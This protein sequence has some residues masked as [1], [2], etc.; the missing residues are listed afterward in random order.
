[1][2]SSDNGFSDMLDPTGVDNREAPFS[3]ETASVFIAVCSS[4]AQ[5]PLIGTTGSFNSQGHAPAL[6]KQML[7]SD[8]DNQLFAAITTV[9]TVRD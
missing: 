2:K 9:E 7:Q 1:M 3:T 6:S 4:A 8:Y 5:I